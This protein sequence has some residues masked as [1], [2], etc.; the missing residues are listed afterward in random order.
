VAKK[1]ASETLKSFLVELGRDP[2]KLAA[3][4]QDP[5]AAMAAAG[6]SKSHQ[7]ALRSRKADRIRKALGAGP[8]AFCCIL[9][10]FD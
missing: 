6:L 10:R 1:S 4:D 7:A 5:D 3:F 9:I 2:K 8:R